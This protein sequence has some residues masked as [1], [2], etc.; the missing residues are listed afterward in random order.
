[1]VVVVGPGQDAVEAEALRIAPKARI[2]QQKQRR[3]TADAVLAAR[4]A[5]AEKPDDILVLFADT[6]LVRPKLLSDLRAALA[7][8]QASPCSASCRPILPAMAGW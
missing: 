2:Y 7:K 8:A 6:P 4:Q 3:G 5:L 1:M